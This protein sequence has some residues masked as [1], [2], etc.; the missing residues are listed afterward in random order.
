MRPK[1][2]LLDFHDA[3]VV[4]F[5]LRGAV[6]LHGYGTSGLWLIMALLE[7]MT[8]IPRASHLASLTKKNE[9]RKALNIILHT[10]SSKK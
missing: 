7:K 6:D 2:P 5:L 10:Y 8:W 1:T 3:F 4:G 9:N